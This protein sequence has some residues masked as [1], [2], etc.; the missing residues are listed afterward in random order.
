MFRINLTEGGFNGI[1]NKIV[2]RV[3]R[4]DVCFLRMQGI[5]NNKRII[6]A[7]MG[8]F[9]AFVVVSQCRAVDTVTIDKVRDKG[10]LEDAD[11]QT[12]DSFVSSAVKEL[13]ETEDFTSVTKIRAVI[14]ARSSSD[15]ESAKAQYGDQFSQSAYTHISGALEAAK[16]L[17]PVERRFR[18]TLNLLILADSLHDL[19]LAGLAMK[20]AGDENEAVRYWAVRCITDAS[21]VE[22]LN[23]QEAA[24]QELA[25]KIA[26]QLKKSVESS[27]PEILALMAEFAAKIDIPQGEELLL[28]IADMRIK[29][30][31]DWTVKN[32]LLD[33][34][35]L[36][37]LD[38]KIPL[39]SA[40]K[41]DVGRRFG[42]LYSYAIQRYVKGKDVLSDTQKNQLA[43][44]L[45]E[46]E[47]SCIVRRLKVTQS[48]VKNAVEQGDFAALMQEHGRMLGDE[49]KAGQ[50]SLKLNFDYGK[51]PDGSRRVAPLVLPDPPKEL[52]PSAK[53]GTGAGN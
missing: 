8:V 3:I 16:Q 40:S 25:G 26:E 47:A 12:I 51:E 42:Q 4:K 1:F 31:A 20:W 18:V 9:L 22:K 44:V 41:P 15:K 43:S 48:V 34:D 29:G 21:I 45:V 24:N 5:M 7:V 50:L 46:T 37:G 38:N 17:T 2:C 53:P 23:S 49:T 10:V 33:S 27:S 11:L 32:E 36:K 14:L 19:R 39:E 35:I 13:V 52:V 30:Y 28:Q 6:F